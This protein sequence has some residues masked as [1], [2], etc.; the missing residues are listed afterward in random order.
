[1]GLFPMYL[2]LKTPGICCS[3]FI[4]RVREEDKLEL[5]NRLFPLSGDIIDCGSNIGFY[6][7]YLSRFMD[8]NQKLI[9]LEP[10][11]RNFQLLSANKQFLDIPLDNY[12]MLN[13]AAH[14][15]ECVGLLDVSRASNLSHL[16]VKPPSEN[17]PSL[18][19]VSC[20]TIDFIVE[21]YELNLMFIR[22]DAEGHE[23]EILNGMRSTSAHGPCGFTILIEVHP[24]AYSES[25]SFVNELNFLYD[26]NFE[27]RFIVSA[28]QAIPPLFESLGLLPTDVV[29]SDGFERG[30]Y[31]QISREDSVKLVSAIP[32][33]CRYI[34]LSKK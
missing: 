8:D 28:G 24:S 33:C 4:N 6:P 11:M 22:M 13:V 15:S 10:D 7:L 23:V 16:I 12:T 18:Q 5:I 9:S 21:K 30:F 31:S 32:K 17:C 25:R 27:T 2:D 29:P 34:A 14:S 19:S 3:L 1:M 20:T 26:N